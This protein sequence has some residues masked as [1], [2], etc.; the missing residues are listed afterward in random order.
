MKIVKLELSER[1]YP[2]VIT[3]DDFNN[4][5]G[6]LKQG[7]LGNE[8]FIISNPIISRLYGQALKT[9][10]LAVEI[11]S[12]VYNIK[13]SESSKSIDQYIKTISKISSIDTKKRLFCI[14]LG[15]G[16][17]GDLTGFVAATYKR[18]IPYI[19]VPTTLLAQVDSAI[20][21]KTAI[22]LASGKN[23]VGAFFQPKLVYS[24]V[25]LLA[26]LPKRQISSGLAE[27]VKYGM[28]I[29]KN[30]FAFLEKNYQK[31]LKLD[32]DCLIRIISTA[33]KIKA[34][35]VANDEK[36]TKGLRT[37]LNFGHTIG[38]ALET[39]A[40]YTNLNHGEAISIG[41]VGA[42]RIAQ[43]IGIL[44]SKVTQQ[45]IDLL[46]KF[47]LPVKAKKIDLKKVY[48]AFYRDK[49]FINGKIRMV[50]PSRIGHVIVTEDIPFEII[51]KI[52]KRSVN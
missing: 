44:E 17:V 46:Q 23:L 13:D 35:I 43:E 3:K 14:A 37:I 39:A 49:K 26:S 21:G 34:R 11:K 40:D 7:A 19:Q 41:M 16:V 20:G 10:L 8:A 2:I 24:N 30:L 28:I 25:S 9:A 31:I 52:I 15:G 51:Q 33:S 5:A 6:R 47:K 18:G 12:N 27:V 38:H 48:Q 22:D 36:E 50:V 1:S 4:L 29:D 32:K 45:L 42:C